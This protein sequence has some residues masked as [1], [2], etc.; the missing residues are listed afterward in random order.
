MLLEELQD[1]F[2]RWAVG[3]NLI[4]ERVL[5]VFVVGPLEQHRVVLVLLQLVSVDIPPE[6]YVFGGAHVDLAGHEV[7]DLVDP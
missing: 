3:E 7:P 1:V 6:P 4:D 5:A 2:D